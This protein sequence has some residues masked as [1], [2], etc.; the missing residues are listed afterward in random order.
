MM[1][2]QDRIEWIREDS[3][4]N[5]SFL[6]RSLPMNLQLFSDGGSGEKTETAT[7]KKREKAREDGQV[8]K[9]VEV[10]TAMMLVAVFAT[11]KIWG[12]EMVRK[13]IEIMVKAFSMFHLEQLTLREASTIYS[14]MLFDG[15]IAIL[16]IFG[17]SLVVAIIANVMQVGWHPTG[18]P[19]QPKLNRLSPIQGFKRLFL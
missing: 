4:L 3:E 18:K 10:T 13:A 5:R 14:E 6:S 2:S 8:A 16:P 11:L 1:N 17:V 7:P 9:S 12:P 15:L 19:L